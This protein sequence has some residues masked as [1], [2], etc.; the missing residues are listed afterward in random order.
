MKAAKNPLDL[1]LTIDQVA[2]LLNLTAGRVRAMTS[3]GRI[4]QSGRGRWN[5]LQVNHDYIAYTKEEQKS[6]TKT[7]SETRVRDA[8][9]AEIELRM[10]RQDREVIPL[11]EAMATI[12]DVTGIY[13]QFMSSL[14]A[15]I[16]R[17]QNERHRIE[18]IC[19]AERARVSDHFLEK[20]SSLRT[21]IPIAEADGED[22]A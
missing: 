18:A 3:E 19:D 16:T 22:D 2:E 8:R 7:A 14:P 1:S 4:K 9:A 15:R 11:A 20:S 13:L 21:G 5:L 17:E 6:K 12:D 10:A